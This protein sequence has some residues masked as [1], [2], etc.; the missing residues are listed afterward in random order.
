MGTPKQTHTIYRDD[1]LIVSGLLS[2]SEIEKFVKQDARKEN[3][4]GRLAVYTVVGPL[5]LKRTGGLRRGKMYWESGSSNPDALAGQN[6][7]L[8]EATMAVA[9][10]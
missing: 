1:D 3:A 8:V 10:G 9:L 7:S 6:G 4:Q 2:M 5:G